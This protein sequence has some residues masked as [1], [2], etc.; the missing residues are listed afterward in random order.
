M[1]GANSSSDD[2]SAFPGSMSLSS[3]IR[4]FSLKYLLTVGKDLVAVDASEMSEPGGST[5]GENLYR[6]WDW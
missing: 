2:L 5:N 3:D 1:F 4:N 6:R